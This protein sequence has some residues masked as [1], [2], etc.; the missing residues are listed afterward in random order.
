MAD[1]DNKPTPLTYFA[2]VAEVTFWTIA[3]WFVGMSPEENHSNKGVAWCRV[4]AYRW[5]AWHFRKYVKYSDDWWGR[6][7]LAWCYQ[8]L[9]MHESALHHYRIAYT[10]AK[11]AD[12]ACCLAHAELT[13]GS[14]V[15]AQQLVGDLR[16]RRDELSPELTSAFAELEEQLSTYEV[17][18][19]D[20]G[21]DVVV[22]PR[23]PELDTSRR[24]ERRLTPA[25]LRAG[26]TFAFVFFVL[27]AR[28]LFSWPGTA[29]ADY[30]HLLLRA[31]PMAVL[32]CF[33]LLVVYVPIIA[34]VQSVLGW[35]LDNWQAGVLGVALVPGPYVIFLALTYDRGR[36]PTTLVG[37]VEALTRS[38]IDF[39]LWLLPF[40]FGGVL[41]AV[42]FATPTSIVP[43]HASEVPRLPTNDANPSG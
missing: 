28:L 25:L 10:K 9:E 14:V 30:I 16:G 15:A 36:S 11:R 19:T 43:R 13:A 24:K 42:R 38:P 40:C 22:E 18:T 29:P 7:S 12:I 4:G 2:V 26:V 31:V 35:R 3:Y 21:R 37:W 32:F 8:R 33:G 41:F 39:V 34:F 20:A 23:E 6:V 27:S 5:A 1:P 17:N